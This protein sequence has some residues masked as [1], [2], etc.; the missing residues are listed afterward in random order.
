MAGPRIMEGTQCLHLAHAIV[1]PGGQMAHA[2]VVVPGEG[3]GQA[4]MQALHRVAPVEV[5]I[6]CEAIEH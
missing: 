4:Q 5:F 6:G 2:G 1:G 3:A